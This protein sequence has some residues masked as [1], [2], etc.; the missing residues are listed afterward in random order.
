VQV[1]LA[2]PK[3][4]LQDSTADLLKSSG[5]ALGGYTQGSRSYRP[6]CKSQPDLF[7]KVFQERDIAIQVAIG[8]YDLGVCRLDWVDE[9]LAK[10]PS[11]AVVK[12]RDLGYGR[13]ELHVVAAESSKLK[14]LDG[15]G[16]ST[17]S[18]RIVSEYPNFAEAFALSQRLKRFR[19]FPVW[20]VASGYLPENA[21]LAIVTASS[22]SELG[23]QGLVSLA[24]LLESSAYLIANRNSLESRE[25]GPVLNTLFSADV[26]NLAGGEPEAVGEVVGLPPDS[27]NKQVTLA[28]PDGHQQKHVVDLLTRAEIGI[29]GYELG[30]PTR[31]PKVDVQGF[32][33]T[34]TR[35]QDMPLQVANQCFDLAITGRDWLRD[36]LARF[37]SSPVEELLDLEMGRVKVVAVVHNDVPVSRTGELRSRG[38]E[39]A[40]RVASEYVNIADRYAHDNHLAPCKIIPTW[41]ASEAFLPEDADVLIENTETGSTIEKNNLKIIDVLFESTACLIANSG[42]LADPAKRDKIDRFVRT[43]R[44]TLESGPAA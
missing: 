15:L 30:T 5:L 44:W 18:L 20:G 24:N 1:K 41:G 36:H 35:P 23:K 8:N 9:L 12:V 13:R 6:Q 7:T 2:L 22:A 31:R 28:L 33:A 39:S 17:D 3:G 21:E 40:L 10:Y 26:S 34:V 32:A 42:S 19:I 25:V 37:P 27:G 43:L 11:D 38:R 29:E 4:P 14:S 16:A